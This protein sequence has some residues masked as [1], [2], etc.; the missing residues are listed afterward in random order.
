MKVK[1][2]LCRRK[3]VTYYFYKLINSISIFDYCVL[4]RKALNETCFKLRIIIY[5]F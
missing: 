5:F 1:S 4:F 3:T 2:E